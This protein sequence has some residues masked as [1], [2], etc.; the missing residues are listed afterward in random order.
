MEMPI[1]VREH[2]N[3]WYSMKAYFLSKTFADVPCQVCFKILTKFTHQK[4]IF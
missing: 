4:F 2:M 1:F 3:Y